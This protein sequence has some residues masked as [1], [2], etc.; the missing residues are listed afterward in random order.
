ME[1]LI[2]RSVM[3]GVDK[4]PDKWFEKVPGGFYKA[5]EEGDRE[6]SGS[7]SKQKD[8]NKKDGQK[9]RD[10]NDNRDDRYRSNGH[11]RR[12]R[13]SRSSYDGGGDDDDDEDDRYYSDNDRQRPRREKSRRRPQSSD[14]DRYGYDDGHR[15]PPREGPH[16]RYSDDRRES[17]RPSS[18]RDQFNDRSRP[19]TGGSDRPPNPFAPGPY[20]DTG[21][22]ARAASGGAPYPRSSNPQSPAFPS[23]RSVQA[24]QVPPSRGGSI[25]TGYVPYAHIY[26]SST[27]KNQQQPFSPPPPADS[28]R[29]NTADAESPTMSPPFQQSYQQN[30]LAQQA[31]T[32][33]A[34]GAGT[35]YTGQPGFI[36]QK[37]WDP[38]CHY[39]PRQSTG[40]EENDGPHSESPRPDRRSSRRDYSPSDD[41]Y[42]SRTDDRRA[43][44]ERRNDDKYQGRGKSKSRIQKTFVTPERGP[45]HGKSDAVAGAL[46]G[47]EIA[48][49]NL[50]D[51]ERQPWQ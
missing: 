9:N 28:S 23:A 50:S 43:R 15:R 26:G 27:P 29:P 1:K 11:R 45:G 32:A 22:A 46:V 24:P 20:V 49:A 14:G 42:D 7:G 37:N 18:S 36:N 33:A 48:K 19:S 12:D 47:S 2:L 5:K 4:V 30:P 40:Y 39:S 35:E 44:S 16:A 6:A 34:A 21:A 38:N 31:P 13:R 41:S 3:Y 25:N 17:G 10:K 51:Y 8:S